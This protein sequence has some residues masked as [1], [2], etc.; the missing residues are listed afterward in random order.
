[1]HQEDREKFKIPATFQMAREILGLLDVAG[2]LLNL[3]RLLDRPKVRGCPVVVLPGYATD[4]IFTLPLRAFLDQRGFQTQGWG[5][6]FNDGNIPVLHDL[7]SQRLKLIYEEKRVKL[8]L[9]G[10]SLGGYLAREAA[11]DNQDLVERVITLG[12]PIIGGAKYTSVAAIFSKQHSINVDDMERD[13][14]ERFRA[15]IELPLLSIYS[16]RDNVVSWGACLDR[17]SP[18]VIHEEIDST[19]VGLLANA[20]A[21]RLIEEFLISNQ[22]GDTST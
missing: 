2:L 8:A 17:Y 21:Y 11:R 18:N 13:I 5:L 9:I 20:R 15:P 16:K 4:D 14:D 7:F 22:A 1:M 10:W 19:H 12:S 6:G 3:P